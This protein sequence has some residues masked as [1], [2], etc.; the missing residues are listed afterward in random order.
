LTLPPALE[1]TYGLEAL[2]HAVRIE[3]ERQ[4]GLAHQEVKRRGW[5]V[6]GAERVPRLSPY[7]RRNPTFAVGRGQRKA[8]FQAVVD[9]RAFRRA[10]RQ[11]LEK[12]R[13][14][15]GE[16]VFPL[17]TWCV[18]QVHG[19][20]STPTSV[21][22]WGPHLRL[23]SPSSPSSRYLWVHRMER[24]FYRR[25]IDAGPPSFSFRMASS[26]ASYRLSRARKRAFEVTMSGICG[27]LRPL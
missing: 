6:L 9:L 2:R 19:V 13:A 14:G 20:V 10:Y 22:L 26:Q 24:Y 15:L 5:R 4:E 21:G 18:C 1:P 16:V 11:A 23:L 3:L 25:R 8:F 27:R 12:R 17:G 7:R